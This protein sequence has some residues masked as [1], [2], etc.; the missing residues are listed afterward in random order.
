MKVSNII[1][2]YNSA[3]KHYNNRN[4]KRARILF[5]M[6]VFEL[7]ASDSDLMSDMH[8]CNSSE[9]YLER[10][11]EKGFWVKYYDWIALALFITIILICIR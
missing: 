11:A 1:D 10:I 3:Q 2:K 7:S 5:Q 8:I 9:D 6:I 4:Y